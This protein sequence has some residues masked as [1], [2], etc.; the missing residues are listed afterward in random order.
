MDSNANVW[1]AR[2]KKRKTYS[3]FKDIWLKSGKMV[4][5]PSTS[6]NMKGTQG[7]WRSNENLNELNRREQGKYGGDPNTQVRAPRRKKEQEMTE[8]SRT[9]SIAGGEVAGGINWGKS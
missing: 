6:S 7:A 9:Y 5:W 4:W 3:P 8:R 2:K 1:S